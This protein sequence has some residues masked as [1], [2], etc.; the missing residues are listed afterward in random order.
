MISKWK[1]S[2]GGHG[3][4]KLFQ[5]KFH[6][7]YLELCGLDRFTFQADDLALKEL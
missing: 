2:F 3:L 1:K 4:K 5:R 6:L 7:N